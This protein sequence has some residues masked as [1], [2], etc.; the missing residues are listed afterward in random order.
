MRQL[1]I[2]IT[3]LILGSVS[4]FGQNSKSC[5]IKGVDQEIIT[6]LTPS[7]SNENV[8]KFT[9]IEVVFNV[10]LDPK[11]IKKN[12]IKLENISAKKKVKISGNL[13][14]N[15]IENILRFTPENSLE[16]GLYSLDIK[17]LKT[18]NKK[19]V[20]NISY[21]FTVIS[22]SDNTYEVI[23]KAIDNIGADVTPIISGTTFSIDE[24]SSAQIGAVPILSF[25]LDAFEMPLDATMAFTAVASYN[26]GK[27]TNVISE[28][29][30]IADNTSIIQ[31]D[32]NNTIKALAEGS[33]NLH[34]E[35]EGVHSNTQNLLVYLEMNGERLPPEPDP[36]INNATLLG[37]DTNNNNV[38]DDV[39]RKIYFEFDRPIERAVA[40]GYAK[41][42]QIE[43][44]TPLIK[45]KAR[46]V[47]KISE[48]VTLCSEYLEFV[49]NIPWPDNDLKF[50]KESTLNT[51]ARIQRYL[52]YD[53]LLSGG[54]YSGP[55]FSDINA[56]Y[57]DFNVTKML[58]GE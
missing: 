26:N 14:Y 47:T 51:K 45:E 42:Y 6:I 22:D 5:H 30:L 41:S 35:F 33:S 21:C 31:V 50:P 7:V 19:K 16:P 10:A 43:L 20:H 44:S 13:Q 48:R 56:S 15:E 24:N 39:E 4:G 38:R 55:K 3:L 8:S 28:V 58:E 49:L 18:L 32:A 29:L 37:I 11:R 12:S 1:F 36:A 27:S 2:I 57:C 52:A 53:L 34:V 25:T 40:M 23:I 46:E 9:S 17:T 54:V